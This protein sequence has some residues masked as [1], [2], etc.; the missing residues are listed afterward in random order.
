MES[1]KFALAELHD[2][3]YFVYALNQGIRR[4]G[5]KNNIAQANVVYYNTGSVDCS[6][7]SAAVSELSCC[8]GLRSYNF[9]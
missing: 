1:R 9:P 3:V 8:L 6:P 5:L 4:L 7:L 2:G